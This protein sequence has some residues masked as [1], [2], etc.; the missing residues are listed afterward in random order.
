MAELVVEM[1]LR[2]PRRSLTMQV[3]FVDEGRPLSTTK[4]WVRLECGHRSSL[5]LAIEESPEKKN[6]GRR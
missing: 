1:M 2:K 6:G 5:P 3:R 4:P